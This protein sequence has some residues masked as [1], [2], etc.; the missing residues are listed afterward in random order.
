MSVRGHPAR[1]VVSKLR[2]EPSVSLTT[3]FLV[4]LPVTQRREH[5]VF[6]IRLGLPPGVDLRG[7]GVGHTPLGVE[8]A[9]DCAFSV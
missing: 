9:R 4:S 3:R 2:D 1:T 7:L 5:A 8:S 6:G